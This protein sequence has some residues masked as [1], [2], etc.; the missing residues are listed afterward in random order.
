M[1]RAV[2][3]C[4]VHNALASSVYQGAAL[5][6]PVRPLSPMV[7]RLFDSTGMGRHFHVFTSSTAA[8]AT[9]LNA[10]LEAGPGR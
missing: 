1:K 7:Q 3:N 2:S 4:S 5:P 10:T 9:A 8:A 6:W